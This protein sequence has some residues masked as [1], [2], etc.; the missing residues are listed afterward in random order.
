MNANQKSRNLHTSIFKQ[1]KENLQQANKTKANPKVESVK[2]EGR[3]EKKEK[4]HLIYIF[5][6]HLLCRYLNT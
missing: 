1:V 5:S 3:K 2:E 4:T 6:I